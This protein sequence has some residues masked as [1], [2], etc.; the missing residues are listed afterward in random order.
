[1]TSDRVMRELL[2]SAIEDS[3]QLGSKRHAERLDGPG[4]NRASGGISTEEFGSADDKGAGVP[5]ETPAPPSE[6]CC[7]W[8][9]YHPASVLSCTN[10]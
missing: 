1:M 2:Q 10:E 6:P 3:D 5:E 9:L 4:G 8:H 7:C